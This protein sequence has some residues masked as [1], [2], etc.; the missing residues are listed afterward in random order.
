MSKQQTDSLSD[1]STWQLENACILLIARC[2]AEVET[3]EDL[4]LL[5]L[6]GTALTRRRNQNLLER[7]KANP[8][9]DS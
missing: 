1:L 9:L 6:L 5:W 7:I 3:D 4:D 2:E 8:Q